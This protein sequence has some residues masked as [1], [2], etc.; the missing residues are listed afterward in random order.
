MTAI[1]QVG[2]ALHARSKHSL[3]GQTL[4]ALEGHNQA[5]AGRTAEE[6]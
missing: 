5:F 2:Y 3:R 1:E 6:A 4:A